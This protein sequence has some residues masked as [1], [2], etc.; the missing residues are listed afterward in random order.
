VQQECT[1]MKQPMFDFGA[2]LSICVKDGLKW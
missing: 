2:M 1:K